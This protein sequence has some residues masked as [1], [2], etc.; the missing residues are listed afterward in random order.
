MPVQKE[1]PGKSTHPRLRTVQLSGRV[2][3]STPVPA[4]PRYLDGLLRGEVDV[5]VRE[6]QHTITEHDSEV[7]KLLAVA[8]RP[9]AFIGVEVRIAPKRQEGRRRQFRQ[10]PL[11]WRL[12]SVLD[13]INGS[14]YAH[15]RT[16]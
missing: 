1:P 8:F 16:T 11:G 14:I 10:V 7:A 6:E 13:P 15:R 2:L 12:S 5:L 9:L 3:N 4:W